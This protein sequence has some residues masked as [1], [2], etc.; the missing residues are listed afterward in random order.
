M[1]KARVVRLREIRGAMGFFTL[2][3]WGVY[4]LKGRKPLHTALTRKDAAAWVTAQGWRYLGRQE[5]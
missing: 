1:P 2:I 5:D 3:T 4:E